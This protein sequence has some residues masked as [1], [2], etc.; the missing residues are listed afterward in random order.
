MKNARHKP[1]RWAIIFTVIL[2]LFATYVLLDT[3]M[4]ARP[5]VPVSETSATSAATSTM[6]SALPTGE[7]SAAASESEIIP[8][9]TAGTTLPETVATEPQITANAYQDSNI[10]ITIETVYKYDTAIYVA[11]IQVSH[12]SYLKTAFAKGTYGRNI[13]ALTSEMASSNN[14][15]FAVNGDYYGFR[16]Y[17]FVLRNGVLYRS[18]ARL[19]GSDEA[20][21]ID[22]SGNFS[23]INERKSNATDLADAGAWQMLS[24]GP[25]LVENGEVTVSAKSEVS[26][27]MDSNPRTAVGQVSALHYIFIVSDGRTS[28]SKGLSLLNLAEEFTARNCLVAYNLDGGGSATMWFNGQIVNNPTDGRSDTE[29]NVSDIVYIGYQ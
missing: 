14:A 12:V 8:A 10:K 16:N 6:A 28:E 25:A 23:I 26:Q 20:L 11:D 22:S 4:I 13:K 3:F 1:F 15:I 19:S 17:G 7:T 9:T 5:G 29:R 18:S 2:A 24:F 27:A 21:L